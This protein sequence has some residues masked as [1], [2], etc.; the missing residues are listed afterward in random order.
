MLKL[1]ALIKKDL[2]L[3]W[4][5]KA[6]LA[7]L[8]LMPAILV[9]V[10]SLVHDTALQAT[11]NPSLALLF[12]NNDKAGLLSNKIEKS[13]SNSE[14]FKMYTQIDGK[15]PTLAEAQ[16]AISKGDFEFCIILPEGM[17]QEFNNL[18]QKLLLDL[19]PVSAS[20]GSN[21]TVAWPA[22]DLNK[23]DVPSY[24]DT[25]LATLRKKALTDIRV[26]LDPAIPKIF[27]ETI[28]NVVSRTVIM[29]EM[30]MMLG[31]LPSIISQARGTGINQP[32]FP[33]TG[34]A[35]SDL[36]ME[37]RGLDQNNDHGQKRPEEISQYDGF[38]VKIKEDFTAHQEN[39][40]RPTSTQQNVP[41]WTMFAM[42]FIVIPLSGQLITE[43]QNGT[44]RRILVAPVGYFTVLLSKLA[45]YLTVCLSQFLL[46]LWVGFKVLPLFGS[47]SLEIGTNYSA[48]LA[49]AVAAALAATGF[50][51]AVGTIMHNHQQAST[52][53]AVIIIIAAA[54]GG[55]MVPV[56]V[57]PTIMQKLSVISPL[58]WGLNAFLDVFLRH[59]HLFSVW[60]NIVKLVAFFGFTISISLIYR[61]WQRN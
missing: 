46:M 39:N 6:G 23:P 51:I 24:L 60:P 44:L 27:R 56:Y 15:T 20:M 1:L 48:L 30:E 47:P 54:L 61:L 18:A 17:S 5:D 40:L 3:L 26:I 42:F 2:L 11:Q 16:R 13:L 31:S 49:V 7:L 28:L 32:W 43:R 59:G 55:V 38:L 4:R 53:G 10:I 41:A 33:E 19:I 22:Q 45:V 36:G 50:G 57:M 52:F 35:S 12:I 37:K 29:T 8:F 34:S 25:S 9:L 58:A 21:Y 14:C